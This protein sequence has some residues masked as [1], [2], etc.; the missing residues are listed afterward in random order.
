M[1]AKEN[2]TGKRLCKVQIHPEPYV[3]DLES[4]VLA[5]GRETT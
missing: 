4:S 1:N 2:K 5:D 3:S